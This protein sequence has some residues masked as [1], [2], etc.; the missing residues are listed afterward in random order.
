MQV[1]RHRCPDGLGHRVRR[2]SGLAN[3]PPHALFAVRQATE[4]VERDE[5]PQ[6]LCEIDQPIEPQV[7]FGLLRIACK[8]RRRSHRRSICACDT[9]LVRAY[10]MACATRNDAPLL[11][12]R[13]TRDIVLNVT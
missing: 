9:S 11:V 6:A 7:A 2:D 3:A 13:G 5:D 8:P 12:V 4:I 1:D 10:V